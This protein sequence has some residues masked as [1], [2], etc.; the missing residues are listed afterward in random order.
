ME[1]WGAQLVG[2][3]KTTFLLERPNFRCYVSGRV[4]DPACTSCNISNPFKP[5]GNNGAIVHMSQYQMHDCLH[6]EH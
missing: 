3:W 4:R 1:L 5:D 6:E 2:S